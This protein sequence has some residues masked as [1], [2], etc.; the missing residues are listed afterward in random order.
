MPS[1]DMPLEQLRQY[2]PSLYRP[3]DFESFWQGTMREAT[4]QPLNAE[5]IPYDLPGRGLECFA[6]RFDGFGGG[7]LAGWFIRPEARGKYPGICVYHGYSG[8]GMRPMDLLV[9]AAQGMCVLSM[10][11]RGQNGQSQDAFVY[12]EGHSS[13]WM[14]AGIRDHRTYYYRHV[15]ADAVRALELLAGREE[16]DPSRLAVMG[17][18]QGGGLSLA[19]AALS[20]RPILALAD[21]PFLCDFRRGIQIAPSG[22]YPEIAHFIKSHPQLHEQVIRTLSYFDCLNLAPWIGC[23]TII[24]N[25]LWDDIC[26]PST[27]FGVYNHISAE[28]QMEVYPFHKHEVAYEHNELKFRALVEMT[29]SSG[30]S[31]KRRG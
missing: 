2:K 9:Y 21:I 18:S 14:T 16:V 1:I 6:L 7:R 13:G 30:S 23:R 25:G 8:R 28:K 10:D 26:P 20:R 4:D 19:V 11:C 27:I 31:P 22:P 12:P 15:Y 5:L 24:S 29:Q 17:A 3:D